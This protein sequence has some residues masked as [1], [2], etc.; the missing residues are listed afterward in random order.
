MQLI[1]W[2]LHIFALNMFFQKHIIFGFKCILFFAYIKAFGY[3]LFYS[4]IIHL[5][6]E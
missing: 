3:T 2:K 6:T 5:N 4:V 1:L